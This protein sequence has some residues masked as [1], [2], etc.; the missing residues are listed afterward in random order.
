MFEHITWRTDWESEIIPRFSTWFSKHYFNVCLSLMQ[1][2]SQVFEF[3]K[4]MFY[5]LINLILYFSICIWSS[6]YKQG[7]WRYV[8]QL[9]FHKYIDIVA[10]FYVFDILS[11]SWVYGKLQ[12]LENLPSWSMGLCNLLC[13]VDLISEPLTN[14]KLY[15][16]IEFCISWAS[17][18]IIGQGKYVIF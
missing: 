2:I 18:R 13:V 3:W 8:W 6:Y 12:L 1:Y 11:V 16:L 14:C 5:F 10:M 9:W 15:I 17:I 4:C 7:I